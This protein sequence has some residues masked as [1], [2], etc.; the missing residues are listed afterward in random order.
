MTRLCAEII[1]L[2]QARQE[3]REALKHGNRMRKAT[4]E[5][6]CGDFTATRI[7]MGKKNGKERLAFLNHLRR[8]VNRQ[9]QEM[10]TD[11]TDAH[12]AWMGK[13]A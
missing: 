9:R 3:L 10:R 8:A 11:L 13:A 7:R 2:R 1:A 12:A 6:M 5:E 4:V